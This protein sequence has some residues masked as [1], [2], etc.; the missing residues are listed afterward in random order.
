MKW[1]QMLK[2][3]V[4]ELLLCGI[5]WCGCPINKGKLCIIHGLEFNCFR[6][7]DWA[8]LMSLHTAIFMS[9]TYKFEI[10]S[11][12]VK[13]PLIN[14]FFNNNRFQLFLLVYRHFF[15]LRGPFAAYLILFVLSLF[16]VDDGGVGGLFTYHLTFSAIQWSCSSAIVEIDEI[17]WLKKKPSVKQTRDNKAEMYAFLPFFY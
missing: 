7:F 17:Y 10:F 3:E 2:D 6:I 13:I 5:L 14:F 8:I 4:L 1:I 12:L 15:Q 16:I 11:A 9:S